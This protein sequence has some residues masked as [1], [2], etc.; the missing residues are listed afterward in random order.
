MTEREKDMFIEQL[1]SEVSTWHHAYDALVIERNNLAY[2][3][4]QLRRQTTTTNNQR[5]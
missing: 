3:L 5:G 4:A 1:R 2:E